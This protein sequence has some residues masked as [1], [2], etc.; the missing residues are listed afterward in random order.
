[1]LKRDQFEVIKPRNLPEIGAALHKE[2]LAFAEGIGALQ[3][4]ERHQQLSG[5]QLLDIIQKIKNK[6]F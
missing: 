5:G 1:M 3:R 4:K 2:G 6:M